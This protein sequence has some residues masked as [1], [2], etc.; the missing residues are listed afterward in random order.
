MLCLQTNLLAGNSQAVQEAVGDQPQAQ[1]ALLSNLLMITSAAL[2][3]SGA[4]HMLV[5]K[6][7]WNLPPNVPGVPEYVHPLLRAGGVIAG[8]AS[9]ID[10]A[11]MWV[12]SWDAWQVEDMEAAGWYFSAGTVT[13]AG[14]V[15]AF[16]SAYTC[17]FALFGLAGLAALLIVAGAALAIEAER[18][19]SRPFEVWLRCCC[20]GKPEQRAEHDPVWHVTRL[21]DARAALMAYRAVVS[22]VT[23]ELDY[24]D[25]LGESSG[26]EDLITLRVKL[27]GCTRTGS[28]WSLRLTAE[29]GD[30]RPLLVA[31]HNLSAAAE[32]TL[33]YQPHHPWREQFKNSLTPHWEEQALLLT[34]QCWV[35]S[36]RYPRAT[37]SLAYWPD[38]ND[39]Q[40]QIA[41]TLTT[42]D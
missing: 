2:E 41:L 29:G 8:V 36:D 10:G 37:L 22:G 6:D 30:H 28:A 16:Y 21:E 5:R 33:P 12:K 34:G 38:K 39:P 17:Q 24:R 40:G 13:G 11:G 18:A 27:P 23:M 3:S 9:I 32:A 42:E 15:V 19:R 25:M 1:L 20:F 31:H 4:L 26:H 35:R 14:G 7:P